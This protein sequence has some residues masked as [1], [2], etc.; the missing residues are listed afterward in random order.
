MIRVWG[1]GLVESHDFYRSCD[2][3]GILVWQDFLFACGNY[4][5]SPDF[6]ANVK[7]EAEQQVKRVGHHASLAIWAGN[8]EDYMLAEG[9]GWGYDINDQEGPWDQ[10]PFPAREIY[11]R[12]LPAICEELAGD[13]PYWRSSPYGGKE[14]NDV[15][16]GDTHIWDGGSYFRDWYLC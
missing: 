16:V 9:R 15:T 2:E 8:N 14:S 3:L 6:V 13:V 12:V 5:A 10:T 7:N 11:E 1:G 4:P